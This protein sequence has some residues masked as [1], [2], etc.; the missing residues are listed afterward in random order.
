MREETRMYFSFGNIF[1]MIY[2]QKIELKI[3]FAAH[4]RD[5][6]FKSDISELRLF[7]SH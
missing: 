2:F 3:S 6:G 4:L 1:I 5:F 7:E